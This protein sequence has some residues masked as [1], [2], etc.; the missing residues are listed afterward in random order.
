M[1]HRRLSLTHR[2]VGL[3]LLLCGSIVVAPFLAL[4]LCF[5]CRLQSVFVPLCGWA[6]SFFSMYH[7][8]VRSGVARGVHVHSKIM[9]VTFVDILGPTSTA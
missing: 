5:H 8:A 6:C 9:S 7:I 1:T 3:M 2:C 4:V